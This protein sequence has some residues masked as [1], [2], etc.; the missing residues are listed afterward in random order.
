MS[1]E[2][3]RKTNFVKLQECHQPTLADGDYSIT[4]TQKVEIEKHKDIDAFTATRHFTVAGERFELKPADVE[5]VFPPEGT[6]GDHSNVL[7]HIV[8][9]RST[10]PWERT[11]NG[12]HGRT[13]RV[14]WL[15]LLLFDEDQKPKPETKKVSELNSLPPD[16]KFPVITL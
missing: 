8:L 16:T 2:L 12:E 4:I 6:L 9:S 13:N 14:P 10:L 7:P 11:V 1:T 3:E 15:A 5:A